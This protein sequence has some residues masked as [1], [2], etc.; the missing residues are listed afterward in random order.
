VVYGK[1]PFFYLE[2]AK[3]LGDDAVWRALQAYAQAYRFGLAHR[4]DILKSFAETGLMR[5]AE[6]EARYQ[7]WFEQ[8]HGDEDLAGRG[9][10]SAAAADLF[11]QAKT[12][13]D[14]DEEMDPDQLLKAAREALSQ[15]AKGAG[16]P[17]T[18]EQPLIDPGQA[19]EL[20]QQLDRSMGGVSEE[21]DKQ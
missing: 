11:G 20:L 13:G 10:P 4:G 12:E 19:R 3:E 2:L 5:T 7:R 21:P 18:G 17:Q 14:S 1:A 16:D 6:L 8:A 15:A 9:D